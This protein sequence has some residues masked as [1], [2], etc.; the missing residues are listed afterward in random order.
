M[1]IQLLKIEFLERLRGI[2]GHSIVEVLV[3]EFMRGFCG[4]SIVEERVL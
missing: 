4:H 1:V 3:F 2:S